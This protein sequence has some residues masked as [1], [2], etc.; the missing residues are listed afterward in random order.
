[1]L[2]FKKEYLVKIVYALT[3][4]LILVIGFLVNYSIFNESQP[5]KEHPISS[6][7]ENTKIEDCQS[8]GFF[9]KVSIAFIA[10]CITAESS[11]SKLGLF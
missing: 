9:A 6:K 3:F 7:P 11:F 2:D 1:M 10:G 5:T 4:I 8:G